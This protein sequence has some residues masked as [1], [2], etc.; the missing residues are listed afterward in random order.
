LLFT[1]LKWWCTLVFKGKDGAGNQAPNLYLT[2]L[3]M[4]AA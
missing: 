3:I 1:S 4:E 2:G